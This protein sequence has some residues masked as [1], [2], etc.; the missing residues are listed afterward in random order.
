M[1][2]ILIV[3]DEMA[4]NIKAV[5]F[6]CFIARLT[7][8]DLITALVS[9][10]LRSGKSRRVS[11]FP[12][13]ASTDGDRIIEFETREEYIATN[14][15]LLSDAC[16]N[17]GVNPRFVQ[18]DPYDFEELVKETRYSD[19]VIVDGNISFEKRFEGNPT[20]FLRLLLERTECPVIVAPE[21]FESIEEIIFA[22]DGG[23]SSMF[24]IKQFT[25]LFPELT[26]QKL[27]VVEVCDE[28]DRLFTE[29][30]RLAQWLHRYYNNVDYQLVCGNP[31]DQLFG[32][33]LGM[34]KRLVIM[35]AFGRTMLSLLVSKSNAE[36][37]LKAVNLPIF[38]AHT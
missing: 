36:L 6:A 24:A 5:D 32:Y 17:R 19:L 13:S 33:L 31:K 34:E 21:S 1:R 18:D 25:Y 16:I 4:V 14:R 10:K 35:G 2:Q 37:I 15:R 9:G 23:E 28:H 11:A 7:K 26:R 27:T 12:V 38:I 8:S 3:V 29:K 22:Y 30:E 20:V